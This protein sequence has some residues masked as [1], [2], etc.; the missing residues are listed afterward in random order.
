MAT[1]PAGH[2][3]HEGVTSILD[4]DLYKLTM[5]CAVL[6]SGY[7]DVA[8]TYSFTN[9]TPQ[10]KITRRGFEWLKRQI[11]QLRT[12]AL[13]DDELAF[14]REKCPYF[15]ESY[16]SYLKDFRFS[17]GCQV[18]LEFKPCGGDGGGDV[19][20]EAQDKEEDGDVVGDVTISING[21][22]A[23]TILYEIP[24][25][26]LISETYFRFSDVD[27]NYDGQEEKAYGKAVRLLEGGCLFSEFGTRRRRS[28]L[29]Q[30]I[31]LKG[32]LR[33]REEY[34]KSGKGKGGVFAGTSNVH[35]AH[36]FNLAPI[37]TVAHEWF[38]GLAAITK[39]YL[40]ANTLGL[41]LWISCFGPSVLSIALTDTFG[42][43]LFLE[44]F[45]KPRV[46]LPTT[47]TTTPAPTS[48]TTTTATP[49][50]TQ[51][52]LTYAELFDGV[53]QDSGDPK[54]F[55]KMMKVFYDTLERET[56][57]SV[58]AVG[59]DGV[60]GRKTIVFSDSLNTDLC[61]EYRRCAEDHGFRSSFGVG[62][63]LTND[64]VH[65]STPT[66]KSTPLNIVI[67][68]SSAAGNYAVKISDN[69]GK[70]TGDKKTVEEAKREIG[71]V[72]RLWKGETGEDL[73]DERFRWGGE[74][75][76]EGG[77]S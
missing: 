55:I 63:D 75:E 24:L 47:S 69:P 64:F 68:I 67:K 8:V 27:W 43:E 30:E 74:G 65:A 17:P 23:G 22:W 56:G 42:T 12:L 59:S 62:T 15:P 6:H 14:L 19:D 29:T 54:W 18:G 58:C 31:V 70:N 60:K 53:R 33:A 21:T 52:T 40:T 10:L 7:G 9:R 2:V 73:G 38:M 5:Q 16:L 41:E 26:V 44:C 28:Y 57:R 13:T 4:T 34:E 1:P 11:Y 50:D 49:Q 25:L 51:D 48:T 66:K 37:G 76:K 3:D 72:D 36:R 71:Y 35:F 77:K 45:K 20:V 32:I 61:L 46:P 39:S